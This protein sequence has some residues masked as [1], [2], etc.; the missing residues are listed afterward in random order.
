MM[1]AATVVVMTGIA[2]RVI[3]LPHLTQRDCPSGDLKG[4]PGAPAEVLATPTGMMRM[5]TTNRRLILSESRSNL[6][7]V[8][9]TMITRR[10]AS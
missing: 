6:H 7:L 3:L 8:F 1:A 2:L 10:G 5:E 4:L 9:I